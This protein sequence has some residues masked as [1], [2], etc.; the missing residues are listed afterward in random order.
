MKQ[1]W[2]FCVLIVAAIANG[3][4][5]RPEGATKQQ[6]PK[7]QMPV[8]GR[9]TETTDPVPL[10]DFETYFVGK[11]D[12]EWLM[13]ESALGPAGPYSGTTIYSKIDDRTFEAVTKGEGPAGTFEAREKIV[14]D[15][16][17]KAISRDVTD[18]RGFRYTQ[19]GTVGGDL[20]GIY[21]LLFESTPFTVG[22]KTVKLKNTLRTMSPLNYRVAS[23]LSVDGAP[24]TNLGNPWWKKTP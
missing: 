8:L 11:W 16:E 9:H 13:P 23:S 21:N 5:A 3:E 12:F 6:V 24:F 22:G 7:G 17:K 2:I 18:S 15:R 20:G 4:A 10:L 1:V 14:Y 19:S